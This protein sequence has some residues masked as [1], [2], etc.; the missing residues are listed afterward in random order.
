MEGSLNP[1]FVDIVKPFLK[2]NMSNEEA[3]TLET[4]DDKYIWQALY[5]MRVCVEHRIIVEVNLLRGVSFRKKS[6]QCTSL[7]PCAS[8]SLRIQTTRLLKQS[9]CIAVI[10]T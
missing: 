8:I 1:D 3:I 2:D 9:K 10:G 7:A 4:Y 6:V 5:L